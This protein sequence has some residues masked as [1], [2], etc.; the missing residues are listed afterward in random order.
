MN[1]DYCLSKLAVQFQL[2]ISKSIFALASL[3]TRDFCFYAE[4]LQNAK[5]KK[6]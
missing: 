6:F 3:N 2:T 4:I 5:Q 1:S